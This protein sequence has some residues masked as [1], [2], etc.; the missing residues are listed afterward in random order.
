MMNQRAGVVVRHE[1]RPGSRLI[2]HQIGQPHVGPRRL[3]DGDHAVAR[4]VCEGAHDRR[5]VVGH[6]ELLGRIGH[7][8]DAPGEPVHHTRITGQ[9]RQH[10]HQDA[11][12][13]LQQVGSQ[14]AV[15]GDTS[16]HGGA[17]PAPP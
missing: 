13:R 2:D 12:V 9:L 1:G 16:A 17:R 14:V 8:R 15:H 6:A 7:V 5:V 3:A 10:R 11:G 4:A